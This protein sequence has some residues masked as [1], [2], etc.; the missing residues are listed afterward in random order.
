[1]QR[2][3]DCMKKLSWGQRPDV[4]EVYLYRGLVIQILS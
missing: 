1:M 2:F 4:L 3:I